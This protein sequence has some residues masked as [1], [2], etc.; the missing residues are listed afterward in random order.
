MVAKPLPKGG[1]VYQPRA[2]PFQFSLEMP[3]TV[4][5]DLKVRIQWSDTHQGSKWLVPT[6]IMCELK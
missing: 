4:S 1:Q 3:D 6:D 2:S 5:T